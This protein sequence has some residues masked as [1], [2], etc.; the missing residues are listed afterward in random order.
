MI[1]MLKNKACFVSID[2]EYDI[3]GEVG[4]TN[5]ILDIFNKYES[6]ATLFVTGEALEKYRE[7]V[8]SW[9]RN[10]EI[11]CH[12][13]THRFWNTLNHEQRTKELA[14]FI[15]LYK[16]V[17]QK[18]PIGFRAPSHVIDDDGIKLLEEK[19]FLYDSS[20]VPHYPPFK[21]YRGYRG[22][23][24]LLPYYPKGKKILEIPNAGQILGIPLA[25]AWVA[26]LPILVYK[27]LF[28]IHKPMFITLSMHSWDA[29]SPRYLK[30]LDEIL[31]ILKKAGYQF[32]N[33]K[34][35]LANQK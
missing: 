30:K 32:Q 9:G 19:G 11:A 8:A 21:K 34:Q 24:P 28:I 15:A 1:S 10:H 18:E 29:S 4:L 33:G 20:I 14:D 35:I 31:K 2:V 7:Q 6:P 13:Y 12:S 17:F 22:K 27:T 16:D 23:A 26:K 25:A 3:R 5:K